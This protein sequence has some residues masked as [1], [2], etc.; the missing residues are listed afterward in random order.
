[1]Q[2]LWLCILGIPFIFST[3]AILFKSLFPLASIAT[4]G[5][6]GLVIAYLVEKKDQKKD[7]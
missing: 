1:M 7:E 3:S 2:R 5:G 4:F 6:L